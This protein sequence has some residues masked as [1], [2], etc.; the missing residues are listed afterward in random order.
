[1][2]QRDSENAVG[3]RDGRNGALR[4]AGSRDYWR[5][6]GTFRCGSATIS[7]RPRHVLPFG[8]GLRG[9]RAEGEKALRSS[10]STR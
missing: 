3:P 1:M 6:T 2:R 7:P 4:L 5:G 9:R 8:L 10:A